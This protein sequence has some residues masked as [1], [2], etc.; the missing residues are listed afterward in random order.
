[1][2]DF[3][4]SHNRFWTDILAKGPSTAARRAGAE[5]DGPRI[6]VP[7]AG[8][9]FSVDPE[10]REIREKDAETGWKETGFLESVVLVSYL[11]TAD[12]FPLS[13]EW[14]SEK[15]LALGE[16]Y[17]RA[18]HALPT[19]GLAQRFGSDP[20]GFVR[21]AVALGGSETGQGDR[22]IEVPALPRV[23]IRLNLWLGDEE[24]PDPDV[25]FLFDKNTTHYLILDGVLTLT[26]IVV[27]ALLGAA[28]NP[29]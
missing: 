24:F 16:M 21:A 12:G 10:R 2:T 6:L 7:M 25:R 4:E 20:D 27:K 18:P 9:L 14:V 19:P 3:S 1:M 28:E 17:F 13:G 26:H 8:R 5:V 15:G 11:A 29:G 22:G 23:P